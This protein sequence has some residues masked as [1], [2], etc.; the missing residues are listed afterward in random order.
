MPELAQQAHDFVPADGSSSTMNNSCV[1]V[2]RN[3]VG[4]SA[5]PMLSHLGGIGLGAANRGGGPARSCEARQERCRPSRPQ[6]RHPSPVPRRWHRRPAPRS[7][8]IAWWVIVSDDGV[9]ARGLRSGREGLHK[10][11]L[12]Y[13]ERARWYS[14]AEPKSK[15]RH[16]QEAR[17]VSTEI[18]V[19][20]AISISIGRSYSAKRI[21]NKGTA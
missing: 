10:L 18:N 11:A 7:R 2:M 16:G 3:R 21:P 13:I 19:T 20:N 9:E 12:P 5:D 1:V 4:N 17:I 14:S 6:V 15:R 8:I